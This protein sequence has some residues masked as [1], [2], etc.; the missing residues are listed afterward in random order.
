MIVKIVYFVSINKSKVEAFF[1]IR[2][3]SKISY[4]IRSSQMK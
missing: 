4:K 2:L 1:V 3:R